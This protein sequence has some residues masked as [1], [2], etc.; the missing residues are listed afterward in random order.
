MVEKPPSCWMSSA[1]LGLRTH[2]LSSPIHSRKKDCPAVR[3]NSPCPAGGEDSI[4][5]NQNLGVRAEVRSKR[6]LLI[7]VPTGLIVKHAPEGRAGPFGGVFSGL[8]ATIVGDATVLGGWR[9]MSP[10]LG[11]HRWPLHDPMA[12]P[13]SVRTVCGANGTVGG[14]EGGS[15]PGVHAMS[16]LISPSLMDARAVACCP[17]MLHPGASPWE[18]AWSA[19]RSR[20]EMSRGSSGVP[21]GRSLLSRIAEAELDGAVAEVRWAGCAKRVSPCSTPSCCVA[22]DCM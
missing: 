6:V 17:E 15:G 1:N 8:Y 14:M 10:R 4:C 20:S 19:S 3:G 21:L 11:V 2:S 13:R 22:A 9:M 16:K 18:T 7:H 5:T 12:L